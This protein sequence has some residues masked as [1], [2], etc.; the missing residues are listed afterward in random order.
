MR[1][2]VSG[3]VA[4]PHEHGAA[5]NHPS[6]PRGRALMHDVPPLAP[7]FLRSEITHVAAAPGG[8]SRRPATTRPES[9]WQPP[10]NRFPHRQHHTRHEDRRYNAMRLFFERINI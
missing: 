6:Q 1:A 9:P 3:P 4:Y 7:V 10:L 2:A 8:P 5:L